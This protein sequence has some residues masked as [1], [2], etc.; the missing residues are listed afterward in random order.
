MIHSPSGGDITTFAN[1]YG[2]KSQLFLKL[3]RAEIMTYDFSNISDN[4]SS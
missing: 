3:L 2:E 1:I 4:T